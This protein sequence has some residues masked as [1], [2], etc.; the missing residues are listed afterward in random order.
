MF[1]RLK[2]LHRAWKYKNVDDKT[3]LKFITSQLKEGD[4]A[5]DIGANKGGYTYWM[6]KSSGHKGKVF[7]FEPQ[8][9]LFDY[10]NKIKSI[11]GFSNLYVSNNA[12]SDFTGKTTLLIPN[13]NKP[14]SPGARLDSPSEDKSYYRE[15]SVDVIQLDDFVFSKNLTPALLKVDVEGFE[16]QV[17]KGAE[18]VLKTYKPHLVFECE[19][20]HCNGH[21]VND[22]INY[23]LNLGYKGFFV[24]KG[25]LKPV[26]EFSVEKYQ[27]EELLKA[28]VKKGYSNNFIFKP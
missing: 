12:V 17:F 13:N 3:E 19:Q 5:F 4:T 9:Y 7:A 14:S 26:T 28:G 21:T 16:Y 10:L 23:L 22:V 6:L 18:K 1:T 15:V 2:Y 8:P 11:F 20:R 27:S 25:N 24:Y